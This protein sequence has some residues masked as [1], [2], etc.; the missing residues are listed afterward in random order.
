MPFLWRQSLHTRRVL[1]L[2]QLAYKLSFTHLL[3]NAYWLGE[4]TDMPFSFSFKTCFF[5]SYCF[6]ILFCIITWEC[7]AI[8]HPYSLSYLLSKHTIAFNRIDLLSVAQLSTLMLL[9]V[10]KLW[11]LIILLI[12]NSLFISDCCRSLMFYTMVG[13][14]TNTFFFHT[15]M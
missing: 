12:G 4:D 14:L 11:L 5:F 3:P 10:V 13:G 8:S 6:L 1:Y 15:K 2:L 7:L 9:D